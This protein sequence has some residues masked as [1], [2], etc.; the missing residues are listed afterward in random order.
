MC[1]LLLT[2]LFLLA[3]LKPIFS[4]DTTKYEVG[5][6]NINFNLSAYSISSPNLFFKHK[7][8]ENKYR[9]Y[10]TV[11]GYLNFAKVDSTS[12]QANN[13]LTFIFGTEKRKHIKGKVLFLHGLQYILGASFTSNKVTTAFQNDKTTIFTPKFGL[14]YVLGFM[15]AVSPQ[16]N[17]GVETMPNAQFSTDFKWLKNQKSTSYNLNGNFDLTSVSIFGAY[18]F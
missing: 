13:S 7:I 9:R 14:G 16:F 3:F 4:Q 8:G 12:K 6:R 2:S 1:K 11:L 15:Y 17:F 18:R 10:S 5:L